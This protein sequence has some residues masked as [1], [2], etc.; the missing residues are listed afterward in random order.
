MLNEENITAELTRTKVK[1]KQKVR[2]MN[3]TEAYPAPAADSMADDDMVVVE[4][5]AGRRQ[6]CARVRA[7]S[8]G[9]AIK[10]IS[11][12]EGSKTKKGKA[13]SKAASKKDKS[14]GKKRAD[15]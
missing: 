11:D 13:V 3:T 10:N 15:K 12:T 6:L 2:D 1:R 4:P 5:V 7:I 8:P 14:T 9:P